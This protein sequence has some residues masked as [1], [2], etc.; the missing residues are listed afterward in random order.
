MFQD[1]NKWETD[2]G[3]ISDYNNF[4]TFVYRNATVNAFL[5]EQNK[6]FIIAAKG[7]GKT[8]L[9]SYKRYLL[10]NKYSN[11]TSFSLIFIP[12]QHPY[13]SFIESIK[14]TLSKEHLSKLQNWEYCKR[15]W[16]LVI[17]L[18]ALSYSKI[19]KN[20]FFQEIPQRVNKHKSILK[21]LIN[22]H[23]T[24]EYIFNEIISLNESTFTKFIEDVSN[25][26]AAQFTKINQGMIIFL[27]RF[28]NALE[29]SHDEIWIPIQAGLL[30]AAWD[31][32]RNNSHI[33]MYL[34]IRQEA[35]AAHNSRNTNAISN[36]VVKIEYS[37]SEL[38]DL[39]N[40]LIS[41]YEGFD[42]L[43]KFLGF[44]TFPNTVTYNDENVFDFMFRYSIGRPRD[45]VQF[46]GECSIYKNLYSDLEERRMEL[47]ERVRMVSSNTIIDSLFDELRMLLKCLTTL[48]IFQDFLTHLKYN[49]LTYDELKNICRD[50]NKSNCKNDCKNCSQENHPFCDLFNMGLLGF[51]EKPLNGIEGKQRFKTPY[52]NLTKGLR[53]NVEFFLVHPA[54]REYI[55]V[56]HRY[57]SIDTTYELYKGIL[58]GAGLPWTK[59][60]TTLYYIN[61]MMSDIKDKEL[62]DFF[63]SSLEKRLKNNRSR[64]ATT[65]YE[66]IKKDTPLY[67]RKIID[68]LIEYFRNRRLK[69]PNPITV[70][71]SYAFDNEEHKER[72][73]SFV[74]M[75]LK[76]GFD[77]KMDTLLKSEYPDIDQM[78]T[79]G[80]TL[81]KII[82]VLSPEYKRKADN[83]IGGVW[84][85]FKMIANDLEANPKKYIFVS[86]DRFSEEWKRKILPTRIGN[87]WIVDLEK[88]KRDNYNELVAFI[89]EEREYPFSKVN[90][91]M[92]SVTP[93][94]I[95]EFK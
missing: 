41:F 12:S 75:L 58:V 71:I 83:S 34:S 93:K 87:R 79:Y 64:F 82:I 74:E 46:C 57:S 40:H 14:T 26:I 20:K 52:E 49:I 31:V 67:Q 10:E 36:S 90:P 35:Y 1:K 66:E 77:A 23:N 89:K 73:E 80:L 5:Y 68:S 29:T 85:E 8:L 9:L 7:M 24:I 53:G 62:Y 25:V 54:L 37:K 3:N 47:K 61:Q 17:E 81:D 59:N 30:E 11:N 4:D 13:L 27:D 48:E 63:D 21:N 18:S 55:N 6:S 39:V 88:G 28:D 44:D 78:M 65:K 95:K 70:F 51:V 22:E 94:T 16:V 60:D 50:F 91:T 69:M 56:L 92:V 76:M 86:F 72:V 84:K 38:R 2:A 33:K 42:T 32:M 45:F 19:D 15:L 43:E